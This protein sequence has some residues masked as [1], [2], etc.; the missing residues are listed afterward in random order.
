MELSKKAFMAFL[1]S[2]IRIFGMSHQ[3]ELPERAQ[4]ES[5]GC[6][7]KIKRIDARVYLSEIPEQ[8]VEARQIVM[9][10]VA[11]PSKASRAHQSC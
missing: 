9:P 8:D 1:F 2:S 11:C 4:S 6:S 10:D 5:N 7:S 3:E